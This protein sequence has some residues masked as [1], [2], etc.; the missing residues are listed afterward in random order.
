LKLDKIITLANEQVRIPLLAFERSL[1]NSGCDLPLW[2]I[3]YD[4]NTFEL[5][6][7]AHWWKVPEV[8]RWIQQHGGRPHKRKYQCLLEGNYHFIDTD[9]IILKNPETVLAPLEGFITSCG[10]WNNPGDTLTP[11]S[12]SIFERSTTVWQN[13]VFNTGQFACDRILYPD[14]EALKRTAE[15]PE[16]IETCLKN[17][18][19]EQPGLNLLVHLSKAPITNLT[20]PPCSMESTWAGDYPGEYKHYWKDPAKMPYLIHWAGT[21]PVEG[22]PIGELFF[23]YLTQSEKKEYLSQQKEARR[24]PLSTLKLRLKRAC[25]AFLNDP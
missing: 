19:H 16:L 2:V 7:N 8:I 22:T 18:Y 17:P 20:L 21:K 25:R 14:L 11:E 15:D 4:E 24:S 5:P 13:L 12:Q 3:P 9:A 1:R 10:H 6:A 23:D